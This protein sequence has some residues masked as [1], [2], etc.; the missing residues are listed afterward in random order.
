[1][2]L[3]TDLIDP[4]ELS[5]YARE[6]LAD[7]ERRQG[8]LA[9][10]LPNREVAD[11]IARFVKGAT[12]LIEVAK[13]R[14]YDAEPEMGARQGGSRVTLELPAIG[15]NIPVSEYE[16]MRARGGNVSDAQTLNTIL[17]AVDTVVRSVSDALER[18][19]GIVLYTGKA[20]ISQD[21]FVTEDD[22]GRAAGHTVT[23]PALWSVA[24]TD[25]IGQ[26]QGYIDTYV[27]ANGT[28]PGALLMNRR[29]VRALASLDQFKNTLVGGAT[30]PA[31]LEQVND[32]I[33]AEG[34]PPIVTY[35]RQVK[36][37]NSTTPVIPTDRVI[38]L[39]A[40]V[41]TDAYTET[42][43]GATFWGR[44]LTSMDPDWNITSDDQPGLVAGVY[45]NPKPPMGL[46]VISDAIGLPVLANA[47]LS[48]AIDVL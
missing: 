38:M 1:M 29:A 5:G 8:T 2:A 37:N 28:E 4:A 45:K 27:A 16:Q 24:G 41:A 25:A 39:P 48:F 43:L 22:F 30:R 46:E 42:E 7:Y 26:L 10:F 19:R 17:S 12:G 33:L 9:V 36:V 23:A 21:N 44:T 47:N 40:P 3:W 31:T 14:A 20:T 6:S 18:M 15:Q 13:F 11:V 32:T 35:N 34:L